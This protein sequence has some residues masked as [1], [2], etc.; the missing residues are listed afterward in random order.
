MVD[1]S[2]NY[3]SHIE[4][5]QTKVSLT[6]LLQIA[7]ALDTQLDYFLLDTPFAHSDTMIHDEIGRKLARCSAP[8]LLAVSRIVDV[9]LEQQ[10][11][12]SQERAF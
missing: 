10:D 1:C 6:V 9:L 11:M 3:L 8:T 12:L 7:Y 4:T 2:N 5:A